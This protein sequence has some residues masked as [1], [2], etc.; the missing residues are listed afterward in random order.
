MR[1]TKNRT[2]NWQRRFGRT[3]LPSG[4][5]A[6]RGVATILVCN[7]VL[8]ACNSSATINP[9]VES[10]HSIEINQDYS[11]FVAAMKQGGL[12]NLI[13]AGGDVTVFLPDNDTLDAEG[14]RFLLETVLVADGNERRLAAALSKHLVKG[15]VDLNAEVEKGKTLATYDGSCLDF[16]PVSKRVGLVSTVIRSVDVGQ[17]RVHFVDHMIRNAWDD[18]RMCDSLNSM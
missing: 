10:L 12:W 4:W 11:V 17:V 13:A 2:D 16:D 1:N 7:T 3:L 14:S 15:K 18:E 5:I 8:S 9:G 6:V